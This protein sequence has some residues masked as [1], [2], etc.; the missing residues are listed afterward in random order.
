MIVV[1]TNVILDVLLNNPDWAARSEAALRAI[2]AG[3]G[4]VGPM[5]YAELAFGYDDVSSLDLHVSRLRLTY[6]DMDK[7]ALL[8]AGHAFRDYRARGG[9]RESILPDFFVGAQA[10]S[11][12]AA[13][14]TRD[15]GRFRTAFPQ[16]TV[17]EP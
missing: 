14:L 3:R 10:V 9:T 1:D 17:I 8:L 11:L 2:P 13:V 6:S 12:D 4:I 16:L 15:R 7:R 5:V